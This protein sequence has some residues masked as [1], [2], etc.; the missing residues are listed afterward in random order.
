MSD[1]R[2]RFGR[3]RTVGPVAAQGDRLFR[4]A[5]KGRPGTLE[6]RQCEPNRVATYSA[7]STASSRTVPGPLRT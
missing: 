4:S 2:A 5:S 7:A 1:D 6:H 3:H